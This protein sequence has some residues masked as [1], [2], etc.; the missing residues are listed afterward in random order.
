M[1]A[2]RPASRQ[3]HSKKTRGT[4]TKIRDSRKIIG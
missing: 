2:R 3:R 1:A 4:A